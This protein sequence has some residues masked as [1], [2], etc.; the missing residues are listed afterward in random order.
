ME[1]FL[2]SSD[3]N[4][5]ATSTAFLE[6]HRRSRLSLQL[7]FASCSARVAESLGDNQTHASFEAPVSN[8]HGMHKTA[9][10]WRRALQTTAAE[11]EGFGSLAFSSLRQPQ[12]S[13]QTE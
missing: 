3:P 6:V 4:L 1:L 5:R 2:T 13:A 11:S 10:A 8:H 12:A 9:G 7:S